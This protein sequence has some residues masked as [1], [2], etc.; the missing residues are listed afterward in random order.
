MKTMMQQLTIKEDFKQWVQEKRVTIFTFSADWCPDC[1]YIKPF[2]PA[3]V[4][5]YNEYRFVYVNQDEF[6]ALAKEW[7]IMGIPSFVATY[8]GKEIDRF[9]S[10]MRKSK[11]EIDHFFAQLSSK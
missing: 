4:E 2:M 10:K 1:L 7:G 6:P 8:E 9:V 3:L 11:D 5:K